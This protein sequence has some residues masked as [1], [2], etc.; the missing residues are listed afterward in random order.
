MKGRIG[1]QGLKQS[2]FTI[3]GPYLITGMNFKDGKIRWEE[4]Y[5]I[6]QERYEEAPEIQL[7]NNDVL[8]TKDG[9]I[10]KLLFVENLPGPASLNS[11]L[12]LLR[13]LMNKYYPKYLYYQLHS[14]PFLNHVEVTKTGTTFF[15]ITQ[16][17]TGEYR[18]IL[19]PL[20]EQKTIAAYLD[21]KTVLIDETIRK[22]KR[23][24]EL[25]EE[26]RTA[27]INHAMTHG[28]NENVKLKPSGVEW[29]AKIP[30]NWEV[31]RIKHVAKVIS[32]GTT[33]S[34]EGMAFNNSGSIRFIKAENIVDDMIVSMPAFFIDE[35][36][37]NALKRSKLQEKDILLV[38][39]GATIG[40]VAMLRDD[41]LPA[42]TNQAVCF[43]RLAKGVHRFVWRWL[44]SSHVKN[45]IRRNSV[46]SAQPNLA[47]Q[48]I[49]NFFIPFPPL[50][51]QHEIVAYIDK[52]LHE[53]E[54][55]T[56]RILQE[57]QFL[58]EYRTALINEVV[59]GKRCVMDNL[60]ENLGNRIAY[61][62]L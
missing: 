44:Q 55:V 39:A 54:K 11:H 14:Q 41:F 51:E 20:S 43:I 50:K 22:K 1:W 31:K 19:P 37:N 3:A 4:V 27:I 34:T 32:K 15:G 13:P 30:A 62:T 57:I 52:K 21:K 61:Q 48:D 2:E 53:K 7:Q 60:S 24:I 23:L 36:T 9:T 38:I 5:H 40:K 8:M 58:E 29:L 10:G 12:L 49:A 28:V 17:S 59:T 56:S 45:L 47:M 26:E 46:Q 33:P 25:L 35:E 18:I 42:N 16:E 6:T